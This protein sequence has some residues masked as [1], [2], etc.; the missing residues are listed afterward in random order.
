MNEQRELS[1]L[2]FRSFLAGALGVA[3]SRLK[4]DTRFFRDLKVDSLRLLELI[5]RLESLLG[6]DIPS[7]VAWEI[8]S[9]DDAYQYYRQFLKD[10]PS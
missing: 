10:R 4:P 1:F 3:E 8:R 9:V 2:E 5:S 6:M 7:D